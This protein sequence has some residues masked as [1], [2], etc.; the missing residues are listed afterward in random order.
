MNRAEELGTGKI[1]SLLLKFSL[2][3]I[4]GMVV[5]ALYNVADRAFVGKGV[6][7]LA[8]AGITVSFPVMLVLMGF[9]MLIG[10]G[11]NSLISIRLGEKKKAEAEQI[12]GNS[13]V[14]LIIVSV[15][16]TASGL[17]F[18]KPLLD[19]FGASSSVLPFASSYLKIILIGSIF[20]HIGFGM[21]NFIRG[22]GNPK[23]AMFTMLIGG[24]LN[25]I[26][27]PL[28]IFVF[29]WG[30]EG[31]AAATVISQMV[32]AIWVLS[33]YFSGKSL[34][35][36]HFKNFKLN[37]NVA[38]SIFVLG[39]APFSMQIAA[40]MVNTL[41]N[42]QLSYHG[43]DLALSA[44]GIVFSIGM[45]FLMPIF[46]INQGAQPIIGYNY[47]ARQFNRVKKTHLLSSVV[48]TVITTTG[49][50]AAVFL[51]EVIIGFFNSGDND[52]IELGSH[53]MRIFLSMFPIVGFQIV[54]SNYFQA[55]GKPHQAM[56]LSLSRQVLLLIPFLFV[57]PGIWGLN[58]VFA[59]GP[60]ADFGASLLAG[61]LFYFE[62]KSLQR[63]HDA[64]E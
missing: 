3:A 10:L 52:L 5:N 7:S 53:A 57:L 34:L 51:P 30:I 60:A 19:L 41:L 21:N 36:I 54:T 25:I 29:K 39:S 56:L 15:F 45:L 64:T 13:I 47:G 26:L 17:I 31:A 12:L 46:G 22:E 8:I 14:L 37:W 42:K 43:G 11:A 6:G 44:M 23:V 40:S 4:V 59:S 62:M 61:T 27:D 50:F 35:K 49:F 24:I 9:G 58:G 18:L 20:Q 1:G 28:F 16:L 63:K 33:Y 38:K 2:P 55:V 32:S 48:A